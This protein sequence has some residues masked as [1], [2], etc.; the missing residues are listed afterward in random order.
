MDL[1]EVIITELTHDKDDIILEDEEVVKK[2][3]FFPITPFIAF[4]SFKKKVFDLFNKKKKF[5]KLSSARKVR[6]ALINVK[7]QGMIAKE[8]AR[9]VLGMSSGTKETATVY[10]FTQEQMDIM[11]EIYSK[12]GKDLVNEINYFRVNVL[13]PYQLIKRI[14]K[15]Y[16]SLTSTDVTGMNKD[17][18][19]SNLESGRKKIMKAESFFE[20]SK[21]LEN[22][23][24]DLEEAT[25]GL[26]SEK[27][28]ITTGKG[29]SSSLLEKMYSQFKVGE[30]DFGSYSL[31][32]LK[33][34][35]EEYVKN[36]KLLKSY[37]KVQNKN[38]TPEDI[39]EL[40]KRQHQIREKGTEA[41]K[42]QEV[43]S[44]LP[45][46]SF[47]MAFGKYMLRRTIS[48][49]LKRQTGNELYKK[50]YRAIVD[51]MIKSSKSRK[52]AMMKMYVSM[53]RG[54]ELNPIEKKIWIKKPGVTA[55]FPK[56][57][58]YVQQIKEEDFK[59]PIYY[60]R[61]EEL[62]KAEQEIENEIKRFERK[63]ATIVAPEDLA[64]LKKYRLIN[65]LI[66]VSELKDPSSLFRTAEELR[67]LQNLKIAKQHFVDEDEFLAKIKEVTTTPYEDK[68]ALDVAKT[69]L[70]A[71]AQ[72]LR[73]QNDQNIIEKNAEA[74]RVALTR[75]NLEGK[76]EPKEEP[77]EVITIENV[78]QILNKIISREY[79]S[80]EEVETDETHLNNTMEEFKK[81]DEEAISK[82]QE[83]EEDI[84]KAKKKLEFAKEI[85]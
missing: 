76:A 75:K 17:E 38:L 15:K 67:E 66:T 74:F 60:E 3:V 70:R 19:R 9:A 85:V 61:P 11:T 59:E 8:K 41:A 43:M 29:L 36:L 44:G 51:D 2:G 6:E 26:E 63:L 4:A 39:L 14:V 35:Y 13:A 62:K 55:Q 16:K 49:D 33:S 32:V 30:K 53:K 22:K 10:K 24:R 28:K 83:I 80:K 42:E 54:I 77:K 47:S 5:K 84:K 72:T 18:F 46:M 81:Q 31:D 73:R 45:N 21:E 56:I 65:N 52:E 40:V 58:D 20:K 69:A 37:N 23:M 7:A 64:K 78:K 79:E 71:L 50:T 57:E 25:K 68:N 27:D 34:A 48:S 1:K 12:Y 82:L